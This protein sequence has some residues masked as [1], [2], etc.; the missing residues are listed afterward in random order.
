MMKRFIFYVV[1]CSFFVCISCVNSQ[2][3]E[4]NDFEMELREFKYSLHEDIHN[5]DFYELQK[6]I[7]NGFKDHSVN[8]KIKVF[9]T[10]HGEHIKAYQRMY[11]EKYKDTKLDLSLI[12]ENEEINSYLEERPLSVT[13]Y[14]LKIDNTSMDQDEIKDGMII[15]KLVYIIPFHRAQTV[16]MQII[17]SYSAADDLAAYNIKGLI[18]WP[19]I[20]TRELRNEYW[21]I[22]IDDYDWVYFFEF[23]L[24]EDVL[25]IKKVY[26]R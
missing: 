2:I 15:L 4:A 1:L 24:K 14:L 11:L 23:D 19:L 7:G 16:I 22:V 8:R 26:T 6:L 9:Y 12:K 18:A 20:R 25:F 3:S 10:N 21:E 5:L 17:S 13:D